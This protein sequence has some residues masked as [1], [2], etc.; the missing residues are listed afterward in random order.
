MLTQFIPHGH[1]YLWKPNLVGLHLISDLLIGISYYSIPLTLFY[2]IR[3]NKDFP[4]APIMLLFGAFIISCGTSHLIEIWTLWHPN[5]WISGLVKAI[6]ALISIYTAFELY[7]IIP[8]A[9]NF[10]SP[11]KL[12][13]LEDKLQQKNEEQEKAEQALHETEI[14]LMSFYNATPMMMGIIKLISLD[15]F[16]HVSQNSAAAIFF[17]ATPEEISEK[18]ADHSSFLAEIRPRLIAACLISKDSGKPFCFEFTYCFSE[19]SK[20]FSAIISPVI[21]ESTDEYHYSYIIEDISDRKQIEVALQE[22]EELFRQAFEYAAIGMTLVSLDGYFVQVNRSLCEIVGYSEAELAEIRFQDITHPEDLT[23]DLQYLSQLTAGEINSYQFEKRYI[24]K[25]GHS[26]WI[27]L[28]VS[29]IRDTHNNPRYYIA[30][31][32]NIT[33][34]KTAAEKISKSLQEKEVM[35]KEIHHRVK[36]N[37]QVICSLLNLQSRY[38]EEEKTLKS[39]KETQNRVRTMA[40]VHEQLYQSDSL[41]KIALSDYIKQLTTILFRA[42]GTNDFQVKC[43]TEIED[44]HLDLDTAVPCGLIINELVSNA[45]K[46]AFASCQQGTISIKGFADRENNLVLVVKD[47]G[48]GLKPDFNIN[49]SKS[50]GLRLVRNLTDQLQG[51]LTIDRNCNTGTQFEFVFNRIKK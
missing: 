50:L 24:H 49:Q 23:Q 20:H 25:Q 33:V 14:R 5:Y 22:K 38:I 42:Y 48:I 13:A 2:F 19:S 36:N 29:M 8:F 46:Y 37:L 10:S 51:K 39:F 16:E 31:I 6:T 18:N 44:F 40:V 45:F 3:K 15:D 17:N 4:Y 27:L 30:Q 7:R 34:A 28:S 12:K 35:L 41:S 26:I 21:R 11:I 9:L 1:C 32:Q 43:D 47:D